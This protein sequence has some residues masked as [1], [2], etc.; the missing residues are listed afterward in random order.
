[1]SPVALVL[2][3]KQTRN[4]IT[5]KDE[6][7][8]DSGSSKASPPGVIPHVMPNHQQHRDATKDIEGLIARVGE[9][10]AGFQDFSPQ[11][12]VDGRQILI[13]HR[14]CNQSAG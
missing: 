2:R 1:M 8:V 6:K 9:T 11:T 10:G 3:E 14:K 5:G 7:Q 4:Q 13:V 12:L